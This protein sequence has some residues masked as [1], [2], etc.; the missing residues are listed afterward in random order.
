MARQNCKM[1]ENS[2]K[3]WEYVI[4]VKRI[5]CTKTE[6][7]RQTQELQENLS[8]IM[9]IHLCLC[10]CVYTCHRVVVN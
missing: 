10:G 6:R 8:R 9:F 5:V 1:A 4:L 3:T 7:F 2:L